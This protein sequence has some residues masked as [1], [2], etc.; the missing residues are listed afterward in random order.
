M[1]ITQLFMVNTQRFMVATLRFMGATQS[2]MGTTKHFMG[3]TQRFMVSMRHFKGICD[4]LWVP[5][6]I[7]CWKLLPPSTH[8]EN[9]FAPSV[10][11]EVN[12]KSSI[13]W[14]LTIFLDRNFAAFIA[15]SSQVLAVGQVRRDEPRISLCFQLEGFP[16]SSLKCND[17]SPFS[18]LRNCLCLLPEGFQPWLTQS[19]WNQAYHK[20]K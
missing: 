9:C 10:D 8:L 4:I 18:E 5:P 17:G 6:D 15:S 3:A 16:A 20:W 7:L 12:L 13:A 1:G 19:F 2:F 11:A 14:S